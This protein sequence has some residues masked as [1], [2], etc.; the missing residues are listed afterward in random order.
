MPKLLSENAIEQF[1]RDGYYSPVTILSED[2]AKAKRSLLERA[3]R[4]T[5]ANRLG[6]RSGAN[7]TCYSNGS[8]T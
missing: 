6:E 5:K 8:T 3:S 4:R 2:E 1:D 7:P